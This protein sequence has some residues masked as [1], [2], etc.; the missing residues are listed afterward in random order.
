V[1]IQR[2]P[3]SDQCQPYITIHLTQPRQTQSVISQLQHTKHQTNFKITNINQTNY[4]TPNIYPRPQPNQLH[5]DFVDCVI[6]RLARYVSIHLVIVPHVVLTTSSSILTHISVYPSRHCTS[7]LSHEVVHSRVGCTESYD[8]VK[9]DYTMF[10]QLLPETCMR[11]RCF[12]SRLHI[13]I[14]AVCGC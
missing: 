14:N 5:P 9:Y 3:S 11:I 6:L 13:N 4:K 2:Y 10:C 7:V 8:N 1:D 12:T